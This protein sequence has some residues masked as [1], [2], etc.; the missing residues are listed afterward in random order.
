MTRSLKF[1]RYI[2]SFALFYCLCLTCIAQ[3]SLVL[4]KGQHK[5]SFIRKLQK[6]IWIAGISGTVIDDDGKSF[7]GLFDVSDS[8]NFLYYPS[9]LHFEGELNN[10]FS[11]EGAFTYSQL[12][13]GKVIGKDNYARASNVNLISF[14]VNAKF[15]PLEMDGEG[16]MFSGYVVG[17]LG[18]TYRAFPERKNAATLNLGLGFNVW[19]YKGFGI[20]AQSLAKFALNNALSKNYLQHSFGIVY[21]FS[22]LTGYRTH[23][24]PGRRYNLFQQLR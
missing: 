7:N 3:D 1:K 19:I 13:K 22:F 9:R 12:K 23:K 18:Y 11:V 15:K 2:F 10:G 6:T 21:H 4:G 16:K 20:N 5:I 8:W 17:G 14:D 24:M